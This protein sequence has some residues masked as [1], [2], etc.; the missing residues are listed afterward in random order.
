MSPRFY[1][2]DHVQIEECENGVSLVSARIPSHMVA[3]VI[4]IIDIMMHI[5]RWLNTRTRIAEASYLA[6]RFNSLG[7][8]HNIT[9]K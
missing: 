7:S 1:V 5:A 2:N 4:E 6:R 8:I 9:K 3:D